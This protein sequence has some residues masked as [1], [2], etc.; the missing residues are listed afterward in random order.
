MQILRQRAHKTKEPAA[1]AKPVQPE[2][3]P[4]PIEPETFAPSA[5]ELSPKEP[6]PESPKKET[7]PKRKASAAPKEVV[8]GLDETTPVFGAN[9]QDPN[10]TR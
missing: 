6:A 5:P 9:S 10:P 1:E 3:E 4:A 8:E 7:T 2:P